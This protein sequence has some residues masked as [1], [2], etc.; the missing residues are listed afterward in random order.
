MMIYEFDRLRLRNFNFYYKTMFFAPW[1]ENPNMA[2][3]ER[4]FLQ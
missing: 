4:H 2:I 1:E 3:L